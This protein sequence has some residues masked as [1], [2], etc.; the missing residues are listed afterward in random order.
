MSKAGA[1]APAHTTSQRRLSP[2]KF[3]KPRIVA[4]VG[5]PDAA[6]L[7]CKRGEPRV[8]NARSANI[9]IETDAGE[10]RPMPGS[11]AHGLAMRLSEQVIAKSESLGHGTRL[12][13]DARIRYDA[14]QRAQ[15]Q[16]RN[17]EVGV[18]QNDAVEPRLAD[19]MAAGVGSKCVD[20]Y[21]DIRKDHRNRP[22]A[23]RSSSSCNAAESSRS[24]PGMRPPLAELT[25]GR[26]GFF[27]AA[28][29]GSS[30]TL[31]KPSSISAVSER[32]CA[33]AFL[34][35]RRTRSS[36]K[37]TVVRSVICHD[38]YHNASICQL[39]PSAWSRSR[40]KSSAVSSPIERRIT[41]SPAPAAARCSSL[42]CRWVVEAG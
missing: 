4:I 24:I 9:R 40:I 39:Y 21:V 35:A 34:L 16:R 36:G 22:A 6:V 8:R 7:D 31:R 27:P 14:R 10:D 5:D 25:G 17:S 37:R 26:T 15:R 33:S 23:P 29:A 42:S 1:G 13:E 38:I 19:R 30:R 20:Q 3:R 11:W 41:S 12:P 2:I 18:P 28:R 32:P